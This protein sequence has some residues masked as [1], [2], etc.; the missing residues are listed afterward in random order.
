M[1][2]I[3]IFSHD[4]HTLDATLLSLGRRTWDAQ[5]TG[6]AEREDGEDEQQN[7][8]NGGALHLLLGGEKI[9]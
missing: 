3:P 4:G 6:A 1:I 7:K 2:L 5:S 9:M 8:N